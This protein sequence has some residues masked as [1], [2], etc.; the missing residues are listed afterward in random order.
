MNGRLSE[1][2]SSP[3]GSP[4][5]CV[6]SPLVYILYTDDC[7][8][9]QDNRFILKY[10]CDSVIFSLL[11]SDENGPVVNYFVNWRDKAFLQLNVAKT[12]EML[13]DFRHKSSVI[14]IIVI[15][16]QEIEVVELYKYLGSLMDNK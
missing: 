9:Q 12:K 6:L 4:Q 8:R 10:A 3:V 16:G 1:Q 13:I 15:K 14:P 5:G 2:M 7:R 11:H